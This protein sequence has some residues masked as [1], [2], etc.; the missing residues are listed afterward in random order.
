MKTI[1]VCLSTTDLVQCIGLPTSGKDVEVV[2]DSHVPAYGY[3]KN[4]GWSRIVRIV[5]PLSQHAVSILSETRLAED[6]HPGKLLSDQAQST[7]EYYSIPFI[8]FP[9]PS[10]A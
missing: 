4:H 10:N 6:A 8:S 9:Y 2:L 3:G 5:R 1:S 7:M